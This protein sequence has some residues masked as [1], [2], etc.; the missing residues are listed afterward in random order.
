[1]WRE[2]NVF[3]TRNIT[4]FFY[5]SIDMNWFIR[6]A[7]W[8]KELLL[9]VW[10]S[11]SHSNISL[12]WRRH[13]YRWSRHSWPLS[14]GGSSACHLYC[15]PGYPFI[16]VI[17]DDPCYSYLFPSVWQWSYHYMFLIFMSVTAGIN[18]LRHRC[19]ETMYD[20]DVYLHPTSTCKFF[21]IA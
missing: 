18:W 6:W 21:A 12:M 3:D 2:L 17:S 14:S 10:V 11:S 20:V 5:V 1:M 15:D 13:Q 19:G 7:M 4:F 16:M 9:F 8:P